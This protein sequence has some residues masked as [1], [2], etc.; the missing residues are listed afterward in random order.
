MISERAREWL[1]D[2]YSFTNPWFMD[3]QT[4]WEILTKSKNGHNFALE[5]WK[6]YCKKVHLSEN[7]SEVSI[8]SYKDLV[9]TI[10]SR[11]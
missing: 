2:N 4:V 9:A 5:I 8:N 1:N 6:E 7:P 3:S 10:Y 11:K